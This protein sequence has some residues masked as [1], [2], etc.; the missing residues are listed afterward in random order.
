MDYKKAI[1]ILTDALLTKPRDAAYSVSFAGSTTFIDLTP[2]GSDMARLIGKHGST[3][4]ALQKLAEFHGLTKNRNVRFTVSDPQTPRTPPPP[5]QRSASWK[6]ETAQ[7]IIRDYLHECGIGIESL[8]HD[9]GSDGWRIVI[10]E[11]L[12]E[13]VFNALNRW[14]AVYALSNGGLAF[15]DDCA[16]DTAREALA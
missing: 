7:C 9:A 1:Q 13:E 2:H 11:Q 5:R 16:R 4:M 15:L 14:L 12:P 8:A 3:I 10:S 6:P